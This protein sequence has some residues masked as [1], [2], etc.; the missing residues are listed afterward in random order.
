[1]H[2]IKTSI[3]RECN[4]LMILKV[5]QRISVFGSRNDMNELLF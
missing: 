5:T 4:D 3:V 1:M 2:L